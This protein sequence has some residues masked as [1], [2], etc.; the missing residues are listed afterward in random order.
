MDWI[1]KHRLKGI[2]H[3]FNHASVHHFIHPSIHASSKY[4]SRLGVWWGLEPIPGSIKHK[5]GVHPGWGAEESGKAKGRGGGE[6]VNAE[7][8]LTLMANDEAE[9][10]DLLKY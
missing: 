4:S 10:L 5:P 2:I 9:S 1:G 3:L 6:A 8:M 7:A